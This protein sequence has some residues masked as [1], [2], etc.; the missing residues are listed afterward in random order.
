MA[1]KYVTTDVIQV[2]REPKAGGR[3]VGAL[4]EGVELDSNGEVVTD[5]D[6]GSGQVHRFVNVSA[7]SG[8]KGWVLADYVQKVA[9]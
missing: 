5:T 4:A 2:F 8:I 7:K 1:V 9:P 6:K 3:T